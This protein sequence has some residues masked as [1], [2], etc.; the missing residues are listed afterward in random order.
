MTDDHGRR[1][2][3]SKI[4]NY[5]DIDL[6]QMLRAISLARATLPEHSTYEDVVAQAIAN[7]PDGAGSFER[8]VVSGLVLAQIER[9]GRRSR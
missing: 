8:G 6:G 7:L 4:S 5:P 9:L 2:E 1:M 3:L